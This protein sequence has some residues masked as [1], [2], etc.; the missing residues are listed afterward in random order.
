MASTALQNDRECVIECMNAERVSQR[1][2]AGLDRESPPAMRNA[3][4]VDVT[5]ANSRSLTSFKL[6]AQRAQEMSEMRMRRELERKEQMQISM[7]P[8]NVRPE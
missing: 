2:G 6:C 7:R 5:A 8:R 3:A 1:T 4:A